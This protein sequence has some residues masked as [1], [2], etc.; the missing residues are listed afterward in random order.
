M[1]MMIS[2]RFVFYCLGLVCGFVLLEILT[3]WQVF[4]AR[5][6]Q[7][8]RERRNTGEGYKKFVDKWKGASFKR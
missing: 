8:V 7:H 3:V 1:A 5:R 2:E 6:G 4:K